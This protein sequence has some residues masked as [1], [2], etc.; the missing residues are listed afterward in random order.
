MGGGVEAAAYLAIHCGVVVTP[1]EAP[2]KGCLICV[3][4]VFGI[5]LCVLKADGITIIKRY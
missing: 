5:C 1:V 3:L 4:R 2:L